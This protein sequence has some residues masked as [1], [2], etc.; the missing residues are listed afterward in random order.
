MSTTF[1]SCL[2]VES[3]LS[4]LNKWIDSNL[5]L[6]V[7]VP[8][9]IYEAVKEKI[10]LTTEKK[11][12]TVHV[13]P[14]LQETSYYD[15]QI[16]RL[17]D[18]RNHEKDTL[19]HL[20]NMHTKIL[21]MKTV[22]NLDLSEKSTNPTKNTKNHYYAYVDFDIPRLFR[23]EETTWKYLTETFNRP[24]L[25]V[26]EKARMYIPGC[27]N[28]NPILLSS[29]QFADNVCWRFC[30][31][32]MFG[33]AQAVTEFYGYYESH[34]PTFIT[35]KCDHKMTWE[36]NF[37]AWLESNSNWNPVWYQA[38]HSDSIVTIPK[39]YA[40]L[41]MKNLPDCKLVEYHYPNLSPY[42]PMSA[43]YAMYQGKELLNTRFVNYWIYANGGY[44]YPED[45]QVIRT[46]NVCSSPLINIENIPTPKQYDLM[47]DEKLVSSTYDYNA[48]GFSKGIE[49][50]RLYVSQE[51]GKLCFIGSTLQYSNC[52]KIRMIRGIYDVETHML[53]DMQVIKPPQETWCEKNW[54]PIP[55][56]DGTDGFVYKWY[57]FCEIGR[58]V[59]D[60]ETKS[61]GKLEICV[62]KPMDERFRGMKG[63]TPFVPYQYGGAGSEG[64]IGV[65]HFSEERTP[66][67]YFH[68]VV[69]LD[70]K[71]YDVVKCSE[72]F[73]FNNPSVEFC[74]GFR[75]L[76][77]TFGF[78][79]SQM[80]RDPMYF[81][82]AGKYL[83]E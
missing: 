54:S 22:V 70:Q 32:F 57:P 67:Q 80:D 76:E 78:W 62:R 4:Y 63:S 24:E 14:A 51:T 75:C 36:V 26:E 44:Y 43:A 2:F 68:R 3:E 28:K 81:E 66:R 64:L 38:D 83:W 13:L 61:L 5:P 52:D 9:S 20:W 16:T 45:E 19:E 46:L 40:Y 21:A 25:Y 82:I 73:C 6:V 49:D 10:D 77:E 33:S 8:K 27:W 47:S 53:R 30:G 1:V 65:I 56:E 55:L 35:E 18:I 12:I 37:W 48:N 50:I 29:A 42:R 34:F 59:L 60:E 23:K 7:F 72:I 69:V 31:P 58:V 71:T 41:I 74:I 17:P 79:I 39:I 15:K 11:Y